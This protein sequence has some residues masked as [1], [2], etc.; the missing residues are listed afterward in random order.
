VPVLLAAVCVVFGRLIASGAPRSSGARGLFAL[1]A[2][3]ALVGFAA[4]FGSFVFDYLRMEDERYYLERGYMVLLPLAEF[5]FLTGLTASGLAL[6]RPRAAR[7]VGAVGFVFALGAV[8]ATLG[9]TL[10]VR[11]GRPKPV[12]DDVRMYE[13]AAL[14]LGW[15]L[16]VGVYWRAVRNVRV[17]AQEYIDTVHEAA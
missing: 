5:W 14:M 7:A 17:A 11:N 13:Q 15:L 12:D 6:K 3:G 16:A 9:W 8:A 1:A 2:L 4:L 10:Y